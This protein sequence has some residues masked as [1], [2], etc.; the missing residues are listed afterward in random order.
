MSAHAVVDAAHAVVGPGGRADVTGAPLGS[1]QAASQGA[2][3]DATIGGC[4]LA[5]TG[6]LGLALACLAR[7]V[8]RQ[9][10]VARS[11]RARRVDIPYLRQRAGP[12][13]T[14]GFLLCVLRT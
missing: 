10:G 6:I 14:S 7:R 2:H 1:S 4:V 8:S 9:S 13:P 3:H 12:P 11:S 5:L